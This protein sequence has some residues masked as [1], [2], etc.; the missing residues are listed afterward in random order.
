MLAFS[1][2]YWAGFFFCQVLFYGAAILSYYRLLN[3]KGMA[4]FSY[5]IAFNIGTGIGF[6]H[7]LTGK[8]KSKW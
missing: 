7:F 3:V 6:F 8:G 4:A 1:G 2:V 5:F